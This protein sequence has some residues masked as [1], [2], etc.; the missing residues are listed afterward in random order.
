MRGVG[1]KERVREGGREGGRGGERE[2][3]ALLVKHPPSPTPNVLI[4]PGHTHTQIVRD[5]Y[6]GWNVN[7]FRKFTCSNMAQNVPDIDS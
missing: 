4:I 1:R 2:G 5:Q 3:D 6:H 7:K